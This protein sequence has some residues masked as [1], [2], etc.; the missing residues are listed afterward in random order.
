M[1]IEKKCEIAEQVCEFTLGAAI[2]IVTT[3]CVLPKCKNGLEKAVVMLGTGIGGWMI[4]RSFAKQFYKFCD[5][6]FDTDFS[7]ITDV[8]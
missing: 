6:V 2:G 1:T 7:D 8:L 5:V 3:G 4:G